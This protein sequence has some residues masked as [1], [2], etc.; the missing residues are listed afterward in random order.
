MLHHGEALGP[1]IKFAY[2]ADFGGG[3]VETFGTKRGG[4]S[5]KAAVL[6]AAVV[7]TLWSSVGTA[8]YSKLSIVSRE[9]TAD[10]PKTR[11]VRAW[12]TVLRSGAGTYYVPLLPMTSYVKSVFE[13]L[14]TS[15]AHT[16]EMDTYDNNVMGVGGF[17]GVF[18]QVF[19]VRDCVPEKPAPAA[20]AASLR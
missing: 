2:T 10:P 16:C 6:A 5:M 7:L 15:L 11:T 9:D 8:A 13:S 12:S 4:S 17:Y 14:D 1:R 3:T 19:D 20:R 18:V